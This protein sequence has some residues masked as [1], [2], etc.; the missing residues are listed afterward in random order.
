MTEVFMEITGAQAD[1]RKTGLL[2]AGM[3]GVPVHF[4]FRPEWEELN[5]LAVFRAG[6]VKKDYEITGG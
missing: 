3:V 5:L 6:E 2:T 4:S 1:A